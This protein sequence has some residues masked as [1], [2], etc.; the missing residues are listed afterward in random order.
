MGP[1]DSPT[2]CVEYEFNLH[3]FPDS[4][5]EIIEKLGHDSPEDSS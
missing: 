2:H 5:Q 3:L 4:Y 1:D